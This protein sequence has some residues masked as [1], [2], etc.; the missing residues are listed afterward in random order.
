[1]KHFKIPDWSVLLGELPIICDEVLGV[2][3]IDVFWGLQLEDRSNWVIDR[4]DFL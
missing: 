2:S 1:M 4:T 3:W